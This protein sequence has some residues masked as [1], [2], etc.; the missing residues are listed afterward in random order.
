MLMHMLSSKSFLV[1]F[2]SSHVISLGSFL[3]ISCPLFHQPKPQHLVMLPRWPCKALTKFVKCL[4]K[5]KKPELKRNSQKS[6]CQSAKIRCASSPQSF[7]ATAGPNKVKSS[8]A[9]ISRAYLKAVFHVLVRTAISGSSKKKKTTLDIQVSQSLFVIV[10]WA[11]PGQKSNASYRD[12]YQG[13]Y[14]AQFQATVSKSDESFYGLDA[15][16]RW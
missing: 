2:F 8:T 7:E 14:Q 13:F 10:F 4:L 5:N 6:M 12:K 16:R 3:M 11:L 15:E 9:I 1:A